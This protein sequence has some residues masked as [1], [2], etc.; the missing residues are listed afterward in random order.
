MAKGGGECCNK[1]RGS[2]LL[3]LSKHLLVSGNLYKCQVSNIYKE[4]VIAEISV[5][6]GNSSDKRQKFSTVRDLVV[7]RF[8]VRDPHCR[9]QKYSL[10]QHVVM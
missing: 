9:V 10:S 2:Y 7:G 5:S 3:P 4:A 8:N 6:I 1:N